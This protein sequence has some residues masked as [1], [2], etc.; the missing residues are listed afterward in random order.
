MK[1]ESETTYKLEL[2]SK[3]RR[4]LVEAAYDIVNNITN[5]RNLS[6]DAKEASEIKSV[7]VNLSEALD[8]PMPATHEMID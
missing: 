7:F 2:S 1:C 3:E 8:A 4:I 5:Y 6:K